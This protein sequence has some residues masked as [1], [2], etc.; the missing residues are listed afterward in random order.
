MPRRK[1][2]DESELREPLIKNL[3]LEASERE[4]VIQFDDSS[5]LA[6][7]WVS[8]IQNIERMKKKKGIVILEENKYGTKFQIPKKEIKIG[9]TTRVRKS[10]SGKAVK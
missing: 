4:T 9:I 2:T 8:G 5:K 6:T 7:I 3:K 1:R 10:S